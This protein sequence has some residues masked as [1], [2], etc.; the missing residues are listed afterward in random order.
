[1]SKNH[2]RRLVV[3]KTHHYLPC[4]FE[5]EP[6]A[7][8]NFVEWQ[9]IDWVIFSLG[10]PIVILKTKN[11]KG[12]KTADMIYCGILFEIKVSQGTLNSLDAQ[13]RRAAKQ[14]H[15]GGAFVDITDAKYSTEEAIIVIGNRMHRNNLPEVYLLRNHKLA[16][17]LKLQ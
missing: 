15:G 17:H 4:H 5:I 7:R 3:T 9:I 8:P 11:L 12:V 6:G 16:A 13:I 10:G 1:M 2:H 14:T